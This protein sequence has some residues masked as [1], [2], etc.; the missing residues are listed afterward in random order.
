MGD[1]RRCFIPLNQSCNRS[2]MA[3]RYGSDGPECVLLNVAEAIRMGIREA[4]RPPNRTVHP[5][6]A[7]PPEVRT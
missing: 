2:C 6:S 3:F 7:P 4:S 5:K 1:H